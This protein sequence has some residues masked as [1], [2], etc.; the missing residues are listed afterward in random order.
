MSSEQISQEG[1]IDTD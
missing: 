1:A